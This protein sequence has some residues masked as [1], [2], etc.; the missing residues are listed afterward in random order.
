MNR[1]NYILNGRFNSYLHVEMVKNELFM[2]LIIII[3]TTAG[4]RPFGENQKAKIILH[5]STCE[6]DRVIF[7]V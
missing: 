2:N 4:F 3:T 7:D 1:T 5:F 6:I